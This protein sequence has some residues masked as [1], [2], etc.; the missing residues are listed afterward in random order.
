MILS[1]RKDGGIKFEEEKKKKKK[2]KKKETDT[3]DSFSA[4]REAENFFSPGAQ[5]EFPCRDGTVFGQEN[6]E[7]SCCWHSIY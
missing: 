5:I 1:H 7:N 6:P 4:C 2:I 3:L